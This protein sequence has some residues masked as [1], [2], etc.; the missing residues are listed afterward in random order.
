LA[1]NAGGTSGSDTVIMKVPLN[2]MLYVPRFSGK[3]RNLKCLKAFTPT[4]PRRQSG[5]VWGK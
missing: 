1:V 3:L 5:A 4:T 2:L